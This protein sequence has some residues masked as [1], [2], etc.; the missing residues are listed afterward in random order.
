MTLST[1]LPRRASTDL[2]AVY[3]EMRRATDS[4]RSCLNSRVLY[5]LPEA[6]MRRAGG[7]AVSYRWTCIGDAVLNAPPEVQRALLAHEVGHVASGHGLASIASLALLALFIASTSSALSLAVLAALACVMAFLL[8]PSREFEA[9][10]V[11]TR[12]VGAGAL[13][14]ALMWSVGDGE[15]D[16]LVARRLARLEQSRS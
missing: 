3:G 13:R 16:A 11:A 8:H 10:A 1:L 9:D 6:M 7:A 2:Q 4:W 15:I 12:L 14:A 5:V